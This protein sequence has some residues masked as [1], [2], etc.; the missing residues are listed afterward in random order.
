MASRGPDQSPVAK[1]ARTASSE[2]SLRE[3]TFPQ[4]KS[5]ML[6]QNGATQASNGHEAQPGPSSNGNVNGNALTPFGE[7]P[8]E[9]DIIKIIGQHLRHLGL[10]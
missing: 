10:Q 4:P 1:R 2:T 7:Q 5:P 8:F 9:L 3:E 6:N